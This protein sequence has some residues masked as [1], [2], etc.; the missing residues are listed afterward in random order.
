MRCAACRRARDRQS[1]VVGHEPHTPTQPL[2]NLPE[3]F[4]RLP[5]EGAA[6][7]YVRSVPQSGM[8]PSSPARSPPLCIPWMKSRPR[9]QAGPPDT[10]AAADLR[11]RART[12]RSGGLSKGAPRS[13]QLEERCVPPAGFSAPRKASRAPG[14]PVSCVAAA[15][16]TCSRV[17]QCPD[18]LRRRASQCTSRGHAARH[19][20]ALLDPVRGGSSDGCVQAHVGASEALLGSGWEGPLS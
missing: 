15:A 19:E 14:A 5:P 2:F 16:R 6:K 8:A 9:P 13:Y 20:R 11:Q 18:H 12:R 4:E 1:G 17:R 3:S 7:T 10:L